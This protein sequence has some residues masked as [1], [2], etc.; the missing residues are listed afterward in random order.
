MG[1]FVADKELKLH[2]KEIANIVPKMTKAIAKLSV[3]RK[4]NMLK[5]ETVNEKEILA[6]AVGFLK[7]RFDAEVS[8]YTEEDQ[9]RYDPKHR[10]IMAL[11][12][13]PA[14]YIE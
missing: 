3:E 14:I 8:V 9:K 4:A 1:E 11:P 7:E 10:A 13:Q 12:Y 6:G 2:M 5:N